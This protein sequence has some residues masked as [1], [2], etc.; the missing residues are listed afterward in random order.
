MLLPFPFGFIPYKEVRHVF[1]R[2]I[3]RCPIDALAC[4]CAWMPQHSSQ[5]ARLRTRTS[6]EYLIGVLSL[7]IACGGNW[8][9]ELSGGEHD[10]NAITA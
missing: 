10:H 3:I 7:R 9:A 1:S 8:A 4:A 5:G 2:P 6:G